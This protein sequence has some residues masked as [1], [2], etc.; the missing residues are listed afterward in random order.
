MIVR[1]VGSTIVVTRNIKCAILYF[2]AIREALKQANAPFKAVVAFSDEK[3]VNGDKHTEAS[4]NGFPSNDIPDKF[5]SDD[6]KILVV[7]NKYLTDFDQPKLHTQY[8][9]KKLQGVMAVQTLCRLNRCAWKLDKRDTFI[10]DFY[11]TIADIKEAFDPFYTSTALSEPTDVNV[12]HDLKDALE[13]F[14]LYD[15]GEVEAFNEKFFNQVDAEELHPI[16]DAVDAR[17]DTEL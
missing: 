5:D 15:W 12:L 10:L 7:A 2:I 8:V 1:K 9:D 11:N 13:E 4:L 16:V 17:F 3:E 14:G 6:Y